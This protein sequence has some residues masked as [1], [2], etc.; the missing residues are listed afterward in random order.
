[1]MSGRNEARVYRPGVSGSAPSTSSPIGDAEVRWDGPG[2][3]GTGV[4]ARDADGGGAEPQPASATAR[5]ARKTVRRNTA[6][7]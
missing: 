4:D 5:T 3:A 1:V 7:P 6:T 2:E